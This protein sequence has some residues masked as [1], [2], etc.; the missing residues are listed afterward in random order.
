MA[1]PKKHNPINYGTKKEVTYGHAITH[2]KGYQKGVGTKVARQEHDKA[3][4]IMHE[5]Y[6]VE[7]HTPFKSK[8]RRR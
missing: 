2:S 7:H 3:A 4:R 5:R 8:V 1:R 6:G